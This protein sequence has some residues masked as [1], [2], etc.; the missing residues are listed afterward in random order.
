VTTRRKARALG[1]RTFPVLHVV[2]DEAQDVLPILAGGLDLFEDVARRGGK[3]NIRITVGVQDKQVRT[4]GLEGKSALLSNL[5]IA[6]VLKGRDGQRVAILRDAATGAKVTIPVPDLPDPERLIVAPVP[7]IAPRPDAVQLTPRITPSA[8]PAVAPVPTI[9]P[10]PDALLA[11]LLAA[12]VPT[13]ASVT[14][15]PEGRN[16]NVTVETPDGHTTILNVTQIA[17]AKARSASQAPVDTTERDNA[18]RAAGAKGEPFGG[19]YKRLGGGRDGAFA[20]W[21]EGRATRPQKTTK[22]VAR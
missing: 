11:S 13:A 8:A 12:D 1:Q 18:Y 16:N 6:D 14:I 10:R 2:I 5:Q 9:A 4:L 21:K 20:A 3:L 17:P 19:A 15:P 7:T 22:G